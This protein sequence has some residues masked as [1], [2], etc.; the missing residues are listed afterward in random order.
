M[1]LGSVTLKRIGFLCFPIKHSNTHTPPVQARKMRFGEQQRFEAKVLV[2]DKDVRE[3][4]D[5]DDNT[6]VREGAVL[7][8]IQSRRGSWSRLAP[9]A[10]ALSRAR[11]EL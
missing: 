1:E 8:C 11:F 2:D 5:A 6:W 7:Q 3:Y 10:R 4:V 9:R